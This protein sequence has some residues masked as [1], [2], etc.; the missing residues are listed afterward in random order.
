MKSRSFFH[1]PLPPALLSKVST[2]NSFFLKKKK[3]YNFIFKGTTVMCI[4]Q[5]KIVQGG[6]HKPK[7]PLD[8]SFDKAPKKAN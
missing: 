1:S 5:R 7:P 2:Y 6:G 3:I 8:I 4:Y